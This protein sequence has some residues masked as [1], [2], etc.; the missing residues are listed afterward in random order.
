VINKAL[1]MLSGVVAKGIARGEIRD[2]PTE[3]VA[4][5]CAAPVVMCVIWRTTFAQTDDTPFEYQKFLAV[6]LDI[7][8]KGLAPEGPKP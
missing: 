6:H 7:L 5:L 2:L 4:R 8:L 1:G 3:H